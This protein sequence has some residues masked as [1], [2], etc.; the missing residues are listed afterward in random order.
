MIQSSDTRPKHSVP[1][2]R[3]RPTRNT[4]ISQLHDMGRQTTSSIQRNIV[5]SGHVGN[6]FIR[7]ISFTYSIE[8]I[9]GVIIKDLTLSILAPAHIYI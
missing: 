5:R 7:V 4:D 9:V 6:E 3:I 8:E 2:W 1:A